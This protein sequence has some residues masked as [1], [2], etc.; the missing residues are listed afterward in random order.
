MSADECNAVSPEPRLRD[1]LNLLV[2]E[3]FDDALCGNLQGIAFFP[4]RV[5]GT[6]RTLVKKRVSLSF[7]NARQC[8]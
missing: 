5:E 3:K 4:L 6:A 8:T 7:A 2:A 1:T